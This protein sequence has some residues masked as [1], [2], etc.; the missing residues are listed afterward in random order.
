MT[1]SWEID[2]A[3]FRILAVCTGNICRSPLVEQLL[4][5][6]LDQIAPMQFAVSSAGTNAMADDTVP[7][8][9]ARIA[10]RHG[11]T[12]EGFR[13]ERLDPRHIRDADLVLT[14]ERAQRSMV[15]QMAPGALKRTFTLREFARIL[16]LVPPEDSSSPIERWQ[17]VAALAQRYRR[18][19][20]GDGGD[21][22]VVDPIGRSEAVHQT[23]LDEMLPAITTLIEWERRLGR[24][25]A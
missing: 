14:M 15:V 19:A 6:G 18:R 4:Q 22:D 3:P 11:F 9:I 25:G 23:M 8:E 12:L 21:D 10:D 5:R 2:V 17:S 13:A 16:P 1:G 20:P 24:I 7:P